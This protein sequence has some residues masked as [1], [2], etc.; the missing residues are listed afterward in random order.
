[1]RSVK[2]G[3][4]GVGGGQEK[5]EG[6][7]SVKYLHSE[8]WKRSS[9]GIQP[10]VK[11]AISAQVSPTAFCLIILIFSLPNIQLVGNWR[12]RGVL[13]LWFLKRE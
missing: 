13:M 2:S 12:V 7:E 5:G 11:R 10:S 3:P 1:M 8:I 4:E 9:V 6:H